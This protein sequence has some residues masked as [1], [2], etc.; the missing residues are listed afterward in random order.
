MLGRPSSVLRKEQKTEKKKLNKSWVIHTDS[1][2]TIYLSFIA[3]TLTQYMY[4]QLFILSD[5]HTQSHMTLYSVFY[6]L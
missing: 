2:S 3:Q 1:T 5:S 4:V 6:Y